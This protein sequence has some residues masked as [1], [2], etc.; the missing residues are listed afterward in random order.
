MVQLAIE[1]S[2]AFSVSRADV[3]RPGPHYTVDML[4]M[5]GEQ[6]PDAELFFLMGGDSLRDL[7]KWRRP[8]ELIRLAR[9][10]VM[11]RPGADV[12]PEMHEA[13]I[14]GLAAR[15]IMIETPVL[16]V[17][18]TMVSALLREGRSARYL[19]PPPVLDYIREHRLYVDE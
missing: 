12:A 7:P 4:R 5:M 2:A 9:L 15:V 18:S 3:D 1:G 19:V 6:H 11:G 16:G 17:S 8:D 14:P 13:E 10:I